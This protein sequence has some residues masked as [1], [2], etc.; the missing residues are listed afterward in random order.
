VTGLPA[1]RGPRR[2]A[3]RR[4]AAGMSAL[5]LALA[6]FPGRGE[7][8]Q[9]PTVSSLTLFAGTAEGLWRSSN[10]GGS[11]QRVLGS[12]S[13]GV[14]LDG[15]GAVR[16]ILPLTTDVWVAGDGGL[17]HSPDFGES[18]EQFSSMAG[19]RVVLL[20]RWP[21]ADP[22]VFVG[23]GA[24]LLRSLDNGK[25]W[26]ARGLA[27]SAVH[28]VEW[29]GPAMVVACDKGL[30]VTMDEGGSYEGPG[31]GLPEGPVV[32]MALSSFFAVDPVGF[33]APA[34]G[35]VYRTSDG[36]RKWVPAGLE[37]QKVGDLVWLGPF[38]Y[39]AAETAFYR[40]Q[41]VGATWTRISDSPGVPVRLM[42][43]LA[44]A[45]G[46]EAFLATDRGLFHTTDAGEHWRA[47]GFEGQAVLDV[48]T[49]PPPDP[50]RSK[51]P[52]R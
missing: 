44:P 1:G 34:S 45:A 52:R 42:F 39:A 2:G 6:L 28:R 19:L 8:Q 26:A 20:P 35:G 3:E 46:T 17:F 29:P 48:A 24:G 40:S 10:W 50:V 36:G 11:W 51:K 47:T 15:L 38:L 30:L 25:T 21:Q 43:P 18:W 41:D 49:F 5:V 7:G 14:R 32:A 4:L 9:P 33:A 22:A 23:T 12:G 16:D 27:G 31:E 13:S 37:G